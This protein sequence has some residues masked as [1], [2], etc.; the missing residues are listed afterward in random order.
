MIN[1][2]LTYAVTWLFVLALYLL[3]WSSLNIPIESGLLGF[4]A[5]TIVLSALI[6]AKIKRDK[7]RGVS[8]KS[9][10]PSPIFALIVIGFVADWIFQGRVPILG[11]Y[12]GFNPTTTEQPVSGIPVLHVI[13]IA[14]IIVLIPYYFF[15]F[16][17]DGSR[18]SLLEAFSLVAI[19]ILNNSRGYIVFALICCALIHLR[20][21]NYTLEMLKLRTILVLVAITVALFFFISIA[22]NVRS[23]FAWDD[24]SYIREIGYFDSYPGWLTEHFMWGYT[25]ITSC[26]GNLVYNIQSNNITWDL[27]QLVASFLP[28]SISAMNLA[29]PMY[30]VL[31]LNACTG[32][33]SSAC[34]YGIPG[35]YLFYIVQMSYLNLVRVIIKRQGILDSFAEPMLCFLVLVTLFYSPFTA[36]AVCYIPI[37]LLLMSSFLWLMRKRGKLSVVEPDNLSMPL[38]LTLDNAK[39]RLSKIIRINKGKE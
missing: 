25:Y 19:L 11:E 27:G 29:Q 34:A 18:T 14:A 16:E 13:L 33:I 17:S 32:F 1:I 37:I 20:M 21:C 23:G 4:F 22:G 31:H 8:W 38:N 5:F 35:M 3:G 36:S 10:R 15:L 26:L 30:Q 12:V 9:G 39:L 24:C 2:E 28:E 7:A 6:G